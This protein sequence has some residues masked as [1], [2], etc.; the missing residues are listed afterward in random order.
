[1][2]DVEEISK[3]AEALGAIYKK[4]AKKLPSEKEKR[5]LVLRENAAT[6]GMLDSAALNEQAN[7]VGPNGVLPDDN[8]PC[9]R[10]YTPL[11][12][13]GWEEHRERCIAPSAYRGVCAPSAYLTMFSQEDKAAFS[14]RCVVRWPCKQTVTPSPPAVRN[15]PIEHAIVGLRSSINTMRP[16]SNSF[17]FS[18]A[19][20]SRLTPKSNSL[21][22][23]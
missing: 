14:H 18:F 2:Q 4:E 13:M 12:P 8:F 9:E 1:M 11:C 6:L 5:M 22:N 17:R 20:V 23:P 16:Y 15:G 10:D 19:W 3:N 21:R 7:I